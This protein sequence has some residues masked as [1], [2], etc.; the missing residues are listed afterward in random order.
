[1]E[2]QDPDIRLD[3]ERVW[4]FPF[5]G[6][7]LKTVRLGAAC[8]QSPAGPPQ[9]SEGEMIHRLVR[10]TWQAKKPVLGESNVR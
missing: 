6:A 3:A 10:R 1:M 8:L 2:W 5:K 4:A 7:I 9:V